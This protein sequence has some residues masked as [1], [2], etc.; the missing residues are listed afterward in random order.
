MKKI[1]III[2]T[3]DGCQEDFKIL[4]SCINT[5]INYVLRREGYE[6]LITFVINGDFAK[7]NKYLSALN[8]FYEFNVLHCPKMGKVNAINFALQNGKRDAFFT[9]DDDIRF[10]ENIFWNCIKEIENNSDLLFVSAQYRVLPY[11]KSNIWK[12]FS[13][14]VINIRSL[15]SLYKG[16]DPQLIGSF[17]L[18]KG[19]DF[20]VKNNI[21]AEDIYLSI[22]HDGEYKITENLIY[23]VGL[24]SFHKHTKR[25]IRLIGGL[26]QI[27]E[28]FPDKSK[29]IFQK[30][31]RILDK[32]K[33]K[34][35]NLYYKVCLTSY[36]ILRFFTN[37]VAAKIKKYTNVYY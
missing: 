10:E 31:K 32:D 21:I 23:I 14:D 29:S 12:K 3:K 30:N 2:P 1:E 13:Y 25:V 22:V 16:I 36:F 19:N 26:T 34:V 8:N 4:L 24:D 7:P 18:M 6:F 20:H 15:K 35:L 37:N 11:L 17:I 33:I 28:M 9:I 27:K 5:N